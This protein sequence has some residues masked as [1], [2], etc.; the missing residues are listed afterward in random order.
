MEHW[1]MFM[2]PLLQWQSN[3]YYVFWACVC[4]L[5][6]PA[7]KACAPYYNLWPIQLNSIFPHYLMN[8]KI[9]YKNLVNIKCA[10]YFPTT[11]S[12]TWS[13]WFSCKIPVILVILK[14]NF[15][16]LD[17]FF[18]ILKYQISWKSVQWAPSCSMWV[19]GRTDRHDKAN[20]WLSQLCKCT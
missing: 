7:C 4:S 13:S 9:F 14:W 3:Q 10:L 5:S 12:E 11:L 6:Y 8:S 17:R 2:Q 15:N 16:F 20:S 18:K 1:G 19:D